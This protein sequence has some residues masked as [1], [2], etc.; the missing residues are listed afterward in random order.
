MPFVC[1]QPSRL[2]LPLPTMAPTSTLGAASATGNRECGT[3]ECT[4]ASGVALVRGGLVLLCCSRWVWSPGALVPRDVWTCDDALSHHPVHTSAPHRPIS[5]H[6]IRAYRAFHPTPPFAQESISRSGKGVVRRQRERAVAWVVENVDGARRATDCN[7][8]G[9]SR[10]ACRRETES[11]GTRARG[12][13][14]KLTSQLPVVETRLSTD[15][16]EVKVRTRLEGAR[17]RRR[18]SRHARDA[19]ER[20]QVD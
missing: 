4:V 7:H 2:L 9:A 5:S 3:T 15:R 13:R 18:G 10:R 11:R 20:V 1:R 17:K 16:E 12:T 8:S 6:S 14:L 19:G